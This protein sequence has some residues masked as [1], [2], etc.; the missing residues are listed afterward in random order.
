MTEICDYRGHIRNWR[1]LCQEL[2]IDNALGREERE[3]AII[4]KSYEKWGHDMAD[5]LYG[6][7]A[8]ALWNTETEELFCVR[9]HF[10]TKP[11]CTGPRPQK[12]QAS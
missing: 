1:E 6:M 9:D 4:I 11:L 8:F 5:H 2:G 3:K 7:F 12:N 10:G